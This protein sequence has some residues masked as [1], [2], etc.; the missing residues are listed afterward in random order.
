MSV[1]GNVLQASCLTDIIWLT[2]MRKKTTISMGTA[3]VGEGP[4][5]CTVYMAR[6][7]G[8]GYQYYEPRG[9]AIIIAAIKRKAIPLYLYGAKTG[10]A[11]GC[12]DS[13]SQNAR[14]RAD[15]VDAFLVALKASLAKHRIPYHGLMHSKVRVQCTP[16]IGPTA[17][18]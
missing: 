8:V 14:A 1:P 17:P 5:R 6:R 3:V 12:F 11:I 15:A 7:N 18:P 4:H 2:D 9:T 16:D 13:L 10:T